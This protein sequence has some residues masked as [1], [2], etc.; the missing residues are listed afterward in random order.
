MTILQKK[1]TGMNNNNLSYEELWQDICQSN[2]IDQLVQIF[3]KQLQEKKVMD[4]K[5][6]IQRSE[7][8]NYTL[9]ETPV[10]LETLKGQLIHYID[11]SVNTQSPYFVNQLYGGAHPVA[12]MSEW[13]NAFMNTSMATYEI[14]PIATLMEES[15][16]SSL[17]DLIHWSSREGLM[18][19][20]GSYANMM[21]MHLARYKIN[22]QVKSSGCFSNFKIYMSDQSHYSIKKAAHLMGFGEDSVRVIPSD[23]QYKMKAEDL[24]LQI[25]RDLENKNIPALVVSTLGTTVFGAI[26]PI[27]EIQKICSRFEVWHHVDGA[28][29][30]P[31]IFVNKDL[32]T[33]LRQVDSLTLDFHKL[34][35][36]TFTKA[37]IITSHKGLLCETNSCLGTEYIFHE[38][39]EDSFFDTGKQALQC[40]RKVD[41]LSLWMTWKYLGTQGFR[42]YVSSML[43]LKPFLRNS[44]QEAGFEMLHEPEYLNFCFRVPLPHKHLDSKRLS[45]YQKELRN[46]LVQEG[47]VFINYSFTPK[48]G[49]FFRFVLNHLRSTPEILQDIVNIIRETSDK[50]SHK[51]FP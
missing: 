23:S 4:Y 37:L 26:D 45:Q 2:L 25:Q 39:E 6:A 1:D 18:V 22:P 28:W 9:N 19:P 32:K 44:I 24:E 35:G 50:L 3:T 10:S 51:L 13:V 36:G 20:G 47:R 33:F 21:A 29:G 40:G 17:G 8:Q 49:Y 5:P 15:I 27:S 16:I 11:Q 34:L 46:K 43:D 7:T 31:L 12:V 41:S 48:E 38:G 42:N 14:A 30:G